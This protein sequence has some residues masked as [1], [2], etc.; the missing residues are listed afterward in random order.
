MVREPTLR[1]EQPVR[2]EDSSGELQG[3]TGESQPT[4]LTN[5]AEARADLWS[6]QG[7]FIYRHHNEPR[8]QFL[9]PKEETFPIQ[10]KYFDVAR[11]TQTDLDVLQQKRVDDYLEFRFKQKLVRFV[12][13]FHEVYSI[14]RKIFQRIHV[15]RG[16]IDKNSNDHQTKSCMTK[17]VNLNW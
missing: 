13:R 15:V 12:E 7:D 8:V 11:S 16:E 10:L 4:E 17:S 14:E 3:E 1:R 6:I 2:S 9:V 5:D